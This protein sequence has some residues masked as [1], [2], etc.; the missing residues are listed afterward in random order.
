LAALVACVGIA[1]ANAAESKAPTVTPGTPMPAAEVTTP[2]VADG[3]H[4]SLKLDA[5]EHEFGAVKA[6]TPLSYTFKFKNKGK[7]PLEITEVKP[8]CGC[9]KGDFDKLVAPGKEGKITLSIAKTDTYS[10]P[11]VKTATVKTNDPEH[12]SLVLTLRANFIKE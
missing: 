4:G 7:A 3:P 2:P 5:L 8:S 6:G 11:L 12:E 1:V 10:G 9:T